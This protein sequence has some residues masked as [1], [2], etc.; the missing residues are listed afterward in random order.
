MAKSPTPQQLK[1]RVLEEATSWLGTKY[2]H[3]GRIKGVG[4]D[5]SMLLAEVYHAAGLMPKIVVKPYPHDWHLH[6]SR[7]LYIEELLEHATEVEGPPQVGDIALFQFG[8]TFSHGAIVEE[9]PVVIHSYLG[10]G[11]VRENV[12]QATWLKYIG[13]NTADHGKLR[14]VKFYRP[15]GLL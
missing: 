15:K 7:E 1:Q 14:P 11:V 4:V 8:R 9:W 2:H 3:M 10:L 5:C 12:E 6:R 13:E